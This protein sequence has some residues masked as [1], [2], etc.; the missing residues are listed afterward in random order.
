MDGETLSMLVLLVGGTL[1]L[2][3]LILFI[4]LCGRVKDIRDAFLVAHDLEVMDKEDYG[5]LG[6][7]QKRVHPERPTYVG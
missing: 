5:Y 1:G 7:I 2:T 6:R 3:C 4:R